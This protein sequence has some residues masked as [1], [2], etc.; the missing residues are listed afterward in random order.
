MRRVFLFALP[1]LASLALAS[2]QQAGSR[3]SGKA[4]GDPRA[5]IHI[6]L[7]SD[8]QCPSCKLFHDRTLGPLVANYVKTGKVYIVHREFPL[9]SHPHAREAACLACAAEK[10]GE[11]EKVGDRLFLW[12]EDWARSG[13][14]SGAACSV[15]DATT[16]KKLRALASSPQVGAEVDQDIRAGVAERV[17]GT[18]TMIITKLIMRYPVTGPVSYP[19][20]SRFLDSLLN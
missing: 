18:P 11:Y 14:V 9:S 20:L 16:A 13:D 3:T 2:A 1:F 12:Q 8:Y 10:L 15:L 4:Q 7:Y 6:D 17:P 5:P 19:V